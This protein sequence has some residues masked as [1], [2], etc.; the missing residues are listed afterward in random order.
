MYEIETRLKKKLFNKLDNIIYT[1]FYKW[2]FSSIG[3]DKS[4]LQKQVTYIK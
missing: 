3:Q 4:K 1:F 2:L